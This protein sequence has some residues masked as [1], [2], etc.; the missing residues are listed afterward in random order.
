MI[1]WLGG[2]AALALLIA[3]TWP[4]AREA[5][6]SYQVKTRLSAIMD[7]HDK[8]AFQDWMATNGDPIKFGQTLYDRCLRVNGANAPA[9]EPYLRAIQ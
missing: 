7:D 1:R 9:C 2:V 5:Y 3:F 8:A 6:H 4:Y